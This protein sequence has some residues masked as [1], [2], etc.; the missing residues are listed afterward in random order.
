MMSKNKFLQW[1]ILFVLTLSFTKMNAQQNTANQNL[2]AKEQS[3]VKISSFTA[4]GN[5]EYLKVQLN[6]GLDSGLT[7]N[8]I[9]EA[10]VQ[11][12]AYCG[13]PRSLNGITGFMQVVEERKKKGITDVAG[14]E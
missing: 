7:I 1:I 6:K 2:N 14:K 9:K 4:V 13:F 8:E 11:L 5:L 3:L 10:L 12:Y